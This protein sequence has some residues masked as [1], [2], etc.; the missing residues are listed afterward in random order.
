MKM[1]VFFFKTLDPFSCLMHHGIGFEFGIP[2]YYF[3]PLLRADGYD[4]QGRGE[5]P[6]YRQALRGEIPPAVHG[7]A[8]PGGPVPGAGG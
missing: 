4:R 8:G 2:D 6:L 5:W 3:S 7:E 1:L